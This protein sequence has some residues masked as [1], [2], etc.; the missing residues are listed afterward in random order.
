MAMTLI[1]NNEALLS[2]ERMHT[3]STPQKTLCD[4]KVPFGEAGASIPS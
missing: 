1:G 4:T 2:T 3:S